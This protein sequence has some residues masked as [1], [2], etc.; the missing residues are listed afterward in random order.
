LVFGV[1]MRK[2]LCCF[3][4]LLN[5]LFAFVL[6]DK[7]C[8]VVERVYALCELRKNRMGVFVRAGAHMLVNLK[9]GNCTGID[10]QTHALAAI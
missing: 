6:P 5:F 7:F 1:L 9:A 4:T 10:T 2:R 8:A 3:Y